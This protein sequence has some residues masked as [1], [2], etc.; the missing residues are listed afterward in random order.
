LAAVEADG[1]NQTTATNPVPFARALFKA[2]SK[3]R[4][5]EGR[6][7]ANIGQLWLSSPAR[8]AGYL[9]MQKSSAKARDQER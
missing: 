6:S 3:L 5:S 2:F 9:I 4:S 1:Q 8:S 7:S